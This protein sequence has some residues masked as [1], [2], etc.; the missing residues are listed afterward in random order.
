MNDYKN[1]ISNLMNQIGYWRV[2]N[3]EP[4][5]FILGIEI[6]KILSNSNYYFC[7]QTCDYEDFEL[8]GMPVTIDYKN[9]WIMM[10]CAGEEC[11][12]RYWLNN[13]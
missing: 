4:S 9:K 1:I 8:M 12:G 2:H 6:A 13:E 3:I 7:H 5:R 11:D 10:A